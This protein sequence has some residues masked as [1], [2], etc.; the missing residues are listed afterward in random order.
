MREIRGLIEK[1]AK[2]RKTRNKLRNPKDTDTQE[3]NQ[4]GDE[5]GSDTTFK[6]T[7]LLRNPMETS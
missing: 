5:N 4:I 7:K 3:A 1:K 6:F 2:K